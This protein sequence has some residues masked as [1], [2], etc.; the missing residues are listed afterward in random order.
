[1][2]QLIH[3]G[4]NMR[5]F[6]LLM[7]FSSSVFAQQGVPG[8][9]WPQDL[10][11]RQNDQSNGGMIFST[12]EVDIR[13]S[14]P[15]VAMFTIKAGMNYY[16]P[17]ATCYS[18]NSPEI[19]VTSTNGLQFIISGPTACL[20]S[21]ATSNSCSTQQQNVS[22]SFDIKAMALAYDGLNYVCRWQDFWM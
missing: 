17:I 14:S 13:F 3:H 15:N 1:M 7:L 18:T 2:L 6:F 9:H 8:S 4:G 21:G 11:C 16:Q 20:Q 10:S 19:S 12:H 22:M 5:R